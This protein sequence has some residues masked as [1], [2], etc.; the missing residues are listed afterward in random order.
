MNSTLSIQNGEVILT[1]GQNK[2]LVAIL[3]TGA[4][5]QAQQICDCW[6]KQ[7]E[8]AAVFNELRQ[9][10]AGAIGR[11]NKAQLDLEYAQGVN[12]TLQDRLAGVQAALTA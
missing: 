10:Y 7:A 5:A 3:T 8:G 6:N 4:E 1:D 11:A 12:K 2:T 9:S